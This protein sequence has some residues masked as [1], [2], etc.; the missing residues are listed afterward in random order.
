MKNLKYKIEFHTYWH[1]G[2]GLAAGADLDSLV[3]KDSNSLPYVPGKTIKGLI[4]EAVVEIRGFQD[5]KIDAEFKDCFGYFDGKEIDS[6]TQDDK[7][8]EDNMQRGKVF[9][10]NAELS[11]QEQKAIVDNKAQSFLYTSIASTALD[12]N[13][14]AKEHS[15]RTMQV[16]VPCTLFGEILDIPDEMYSEIKNALGYIKRLGQN[17]N[18]GLGRCTIQAEGGE[19]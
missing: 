19:K 9:F 8:I 7:T 14:V 17:R 4:K 11:C 6:T 13:G 5:K 15:L 16:T 1:C 10:T 18:R 2:S 3:V 12:E